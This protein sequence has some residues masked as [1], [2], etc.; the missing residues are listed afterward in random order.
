MSVLVGW[1]GECVCVFTL[2]CDA[3]QS[4]LETDRSLC[5]RPWRLFVEKSFL[6]VSRK[7]VRVWPQLKEHKCVCECASQPGQECVWV[8]CLCW[9]LREREKNRFY[10]LESLLFRCKKKIF[11]WRDEMNLV[12]WA[13]ASSTHF[14]LVG[15]RTKW[16]TKWRSKSHPFVMFVNHFD[17]VCHD[18]NVRNF[19]LTKWRLNSHPRVSQSFLM[20]VMFVITLLL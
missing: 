20:F 7:R 17:E 6:P 9:R 3:P 19:T 12:I 2:P 16:R 10:P 15:L 4:V 8:Y 5:G 1:G 14:C 13:F 18:Y 11:S